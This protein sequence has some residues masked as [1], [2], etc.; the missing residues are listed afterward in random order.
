[1]KSKICIRYFLLISLLFTLNSAIA[2]Q[3]FRGNTHAHTVLSGHADSSPEDVA[4]W[5]HDHGYHF[6]V[7]SEHNKFINPRNVKLP[8]NRRNNFILIP[9]EEITGKKMIHTTAMNIKKIIPWDY[10]NEE[11]SAII[12]N[13][14]DGTIKTGGQAILNHPNFHYAISVK[15]MLPVKNLYLFELFNGHPAVHNFG[16][17]EHPSTEFIWDQLLTQGMHIYGVSSDDAHHFK[18]IAHNRSN[19]GRGWVMVKASKL[20]SD[21]ILK[22]M[23]D[24]EFYSSNGV[25]LK[26]YDRDNETYTIEID[27]IKTQQILSSA[28][29]NGNKSAGV[30]SG[31]TIEFIGQNGNLLKKVK[32]LSGTYEINKSN[33]YVRAKVT[34]TRNRN[35]NYEEFYAWGQPVFNNK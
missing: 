28:V 19:P 4:K 1:M 35:N 34:F 23:L 20:D 15:D 24:G 9:G 3:W 16:D 32:G 27:D 17:L 26:T 6:L 30:E 18:E 10:D 13:H 11:N 14:V 31:Y 7:L 8:D 21:E 2:D 29:I 22:A 33:L 25:F 5:Y 12:Q